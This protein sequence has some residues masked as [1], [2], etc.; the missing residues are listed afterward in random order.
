MR[1]T[2]PQNL[3]ELVYKTYVLPLFDYA[4]T[5]WGCTNANV[6]I[7]QRLQNR[8]AR[9]ITGCFDIINVRGISLVKSLKWQNMQERINYFLC[10]H[11]YNCIR[12]NAPQ[13][14]VNSIVMACDAHEI[15]TRLSN[16]LNVVIPDCQSQLFTRSFIYRAS[17]AWNTLPEEL[18]DCTTLD[19]FKSKVKVYFNS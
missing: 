12:G 19:L 5:I 16:T 8:A 2:L 7:I 15:N 11:M 6:S 13:H 1:L 14:L 9:I 4:C 18:K 3:L 10:I 17:V